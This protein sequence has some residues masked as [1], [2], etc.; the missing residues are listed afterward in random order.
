[1]VKSR[2]NRGAGPHGLGPFVVVD[3]RRGVPVSSEYGM[4]LEELAD[5]LREADRPDG[6]ASRSR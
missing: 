2:E 6:R 5:F 3:D 4:D 1:V